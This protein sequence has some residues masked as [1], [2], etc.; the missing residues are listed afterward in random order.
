MDRANPEPSED[1][2]LVVPEWKSGLDWRLCRESKECRLLRKGVVE[3]SVGGVEPDGSSGREGNLPGSDH[4]IQ[5]GVCVEKRDG[6]Q[7][8]LLQRLQDSA[9][10][11]PRIDHD[12]LPGF[13]VGEDRAVA[14]KR[15][16]GEGLDRRTTTHG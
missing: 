16:H 3:R 14:L 5:V 15:S 13:L 1:N 12:R 7:A 8:G 9:G 2:R 10:L 4:M 11:V 6:A